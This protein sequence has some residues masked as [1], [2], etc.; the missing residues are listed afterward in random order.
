MTNSDR[1]TSIRPSPVHHSPAVTIAL[2]FRWILAGLVCLWLAFCTAVGPIYRANHSILTFAVGNWLI[3]I[4]SFAIYLSLVASL[5]DLSRPHSRLK[6]VSKRLAARAKKLKKPVLTRLKGMRW[7]QQIQSKLTVHAKKSTSRK[8]PPALSLIKKITSSW[9]PWIITH[10]QYSWQIA[11]IVGF[12]WL[13]FLALVPTIFGADALS[14]WNEAKRWIAY[15]NGSRPDYMESF[16]VVDVYPIAHYLWPTTSTYLTN[17]HN[18]VL[19]IITGS[20]LE[21]SNQW[22]G[23]LDLGFIF[24]SLL[25]AAFALFCVSVTMARFFRFARPSRIYQDSSRL[26]RNSTAGPWTRLIILVFFSFNPLVVFSMPAL[27]KSPLFAFAFLW[28]FGLWFE[29]FAS[30]HTSKISRRRTAGLFLSSL[31]MLISAKYALY[32]LAIQIILVLLSDRSRW[33]TWL[34]GLVLPL[35][36]FQVGLNVAVGTGAIINGDPIESRGVQVQQIARVMKLDPLNISPKTKRQLQPIF[37]LYAMGNTYFPDDADRVKSSGG[38]PKIETY[39]WETVTAKDMSH[40]NEAWLDLGKRN[41][42]IY[43]DAFLAKIYGYFDISDPPYVS[44]AYYVK[45][46]QIDTRTSWI[47]Y[48]LPGIR[49]YIKDSSLR[50]S[51]KP[52]IGQLMHGNFYVIIC[53][54]IIC[55]EFILRRWTYLLRHFPLLL[56]MGVMVLSPANNFDRHML[57]LAF[58]CLFMIITFIR[59]SRRHISRSRRAL[60]Q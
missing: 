42:V 21:L 43:L 57:P 8:N 58:V 55:A 37:N 10:T 48:W 5:V 36:I 33:R 44:A 53:L 14:Q 32:I 40:L 20:L 17:Q 6:T 4:F 11:C 2:V 28:W 46:P 51:S 16:N 50:A 27:T 29:I 24:L 19:T 12:F 23:S 7:I 18:V 56:L 34:A 39:K 60:P 35:L 9:R 25:Q 22:T 13:I 3:L 30:P 26:E 45:T 52:V 49:E 1:S 15:L 47:R 41:P 59:E 38:D 54:M 31:I